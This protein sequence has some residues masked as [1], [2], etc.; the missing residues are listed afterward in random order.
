MATII[1]AVRA[2]TYLDKADELEH[3]A[4]VLRNAV[5]RLTA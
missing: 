2:R 4:S 1:N 5:E 3:R